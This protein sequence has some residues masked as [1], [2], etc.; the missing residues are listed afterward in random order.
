[1][2]PFF[3]FTPIRTADADI[4][5][6]TAEAPH[7]MAFEMGEGQHG[8]I[9]QHILPDGHLTEPLAALNGEQSRSIFIRDIHRT[10]CPAV[11]FERPAMFFGRITITFI[12]GIGLD[13]M[14]TRQFIFDQILHPG[15]GNDVRAVLFSFTATL[16]VSGAQIRL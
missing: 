5:I 14:R 6:R 1:M 8:I 13:D 9:I 2:D 4:F 7:D 3:A 10:E 15:P 11:D 16:P 12:I